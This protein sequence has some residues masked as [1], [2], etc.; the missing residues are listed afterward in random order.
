VTTS[1]FSSLHA[2]GEL[3]D[4]R[5]PHHAAVQF[6][7]LLETLP[8][9]AYICDARGLITY[10]NKHAVELWGRS[11]LLND[12]ADRY[13]GS[14]R[15]FSV[16]G[17]PIRHEECWMALALHQGTAYNGHEIVI[18]RPDGSRRTVLANIN[19]LRDENGARS[20]AVNVIVDITAQKQAEVLLRRADN[21]KNEFLAM[22]AHELRNPLAPMS[23]ALEIL[24]T[25]EGDGEQT[26]AAIA[27]IE[28][29]LRHLS[30]IVDDLLDVARI[31][32][33]K[34]E[35][36]KERVDLTSLLSH[37]VE[38]CRPLAESFGH[39]LDVAI[40]NELLLVDADPVRLVQVFSN[41]LTNACRYT[42]RDGRISLA[43][44]RQGDEIVVSVKDDGIGIPRAMLT[45]I[46]EIFTQ[47]KKSS[48]QSESGLGVGLA[49]VKQLVELHGGTVEARSEGSGHGS[50][51]LVRLPA[52]LGAEAP[53]AEQPNQ[54]RSG[55][56][57][58]ILVVDDNRDAA[59][60]LSLLLQ[61][62]GNETSVAHDGPA[63][64]DA[65]AAFRPEVILLDLG[66]PGMNGHAVCQALRA[67]A[68]GGEIVIIALT[69]WGREQDV[70]ASSDAGFD[71]HL[72]KPVDR[73]TLMRVL[74]ATPT[75]TAAS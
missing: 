55:V 62:S 61:L 74:D 8:A 12:P 44:R 1:R 2:D 23:N 57:R 15:L 30:R 63:A 14:F 19:P 56:G 38:T 18:E 28:R 32:R 16:D 65:A 31:T 22:L 67:R 13:C 41:L 29:Q 11:P 49:L 37:A 27:M 42:N 68:S 66:L 9:A 39:R 6:R 70:R 52:L 36:R 20:G 51:F 7:R 46:F 73:A 47:G 64:L 54:R 40:P 26:S 35:L 75:K 34:L 4:P 71:H 72:V 3:P 24:R 53:G 60:S 59:E 43:T 50:E 45:R 21:R 10:F 33:D 69:G 48:E 5:G 58:R 17:A 25:P